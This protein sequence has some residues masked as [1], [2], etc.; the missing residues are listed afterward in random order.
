[1]SAADLTTGFYGKI[2]ATGDFVGRRLPADFVRAWDRWVAQHFAGL[3]GGQCWPRSLALRFL[4]GPPYFEAAM[5]IIVQ[6][7]D[8]VG[9]RF[10]LSIV[11]LLPEASIG[12]VRAEA[13]FAGIE[14][15]GARA[16]L[17]ELTPDELESAL[18]R[19]PVPAAEVGEEI[20][21]GMV[22]WTAHSDIFDVDPNAPQAV[23]KQLLA[24]SCQIS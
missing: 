10:P 15:A 23:L 22:M 7:A 6:S 14:E 13:W 8:R 2:P 16:Q 17:G 12:L 21:E 18:I 5:G 19:L 9:R 3:I 20:V 24:A 11:A 4:A 1:M